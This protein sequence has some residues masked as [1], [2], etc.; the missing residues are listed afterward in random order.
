M[1]AQAR[2]VNGR[3]HNG[4]PEPVR[5]WDQGFVGA[6]P[7]RVFEVLREPEGY[8][9]WWPGVRRLGD[10]RLRL[11]GMRPAT[12]TVDRVRPGVGLFVRLSGGPGGLEG[13]L[14]WYLEPFEE[15]TMVNG[16][17]DLGAGRRWPPRRVL[18]IRSGLRSAMVAL[19]EMLE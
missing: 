13:H 10:G 11:P 5:T 6:S 16:I 8:P 4:G 18:R 1:E 15:G 7:G 14:E 17:T 19:K 3:K 12:V 9:A 2:A